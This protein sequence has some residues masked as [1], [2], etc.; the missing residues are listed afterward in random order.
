M[1]NDVE[2]GPSKDNDDL[3]NHLDPDDDASDP[4]DIA[5]TKNASVETL[6]RWRVISLFFSP[7]LSSVIVIM[8]GKNRF[9]GN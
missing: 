3:K 7:S 1:S 6:K 4:F 5:H 2:A 9:S 8:K